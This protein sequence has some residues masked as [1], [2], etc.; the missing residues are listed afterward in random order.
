MLCSLH[1]RASSYVKREFR[2]VLSSQ[3]L[4]TLF[5]PLNRQEG[6][7]TPKVTTRGLR[8]GLPLGGLPSKPDQERPED[9]SCSFPPY[10]VLRRSPTCTRQG[11]LKIATCKERPQPNVVYLRPEFSLVWF[12]VWKVISG[13]E[14]EQLWQAIAHHLL[15]SLTAFLWSS[16]TKKHSSNCG[17][18]LELY[19][20][21]RR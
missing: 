21:S 20:G 2:F 18:S 13:F 15:S 12:S 7:W 16:F 6:P 5:K 17:F 1:L 10:L 9:I 19:I 4:Q 3:R 8:A 11:H 14:H